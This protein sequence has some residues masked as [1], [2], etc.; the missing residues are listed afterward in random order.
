METITWN[1]RAYRHNTITRSAKFIT[2]NLNGLLPLY[3]DELDRIKKY[4]VK[5][6]IASG[7]LISLRN[8]IKSQIE[9]KKQHVPDYLIVQ[10]RLLFSRLVSRSLTSKNLWPEIKNFFSRYS[11]PVRKIIEIVTET[12]SYNEL[13]DINKAMIKRVL[14]DSVKYDKK[15]QVNAKKFEDTVVKWFRENTQ[16]PFRTE[17]DILDDKSHKLTPDLLFDKPIG[18]IIEGKLNMVNWIDAKNYTLADIP[19]IIKSVKRQ[20]DKYNREFGPGAFIFSHSFDENIHID[21]ALLL[22]GA[23]QR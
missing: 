21:G 5:N 1:N 18:I 2:N 15:I 3:R 10:I 16:T 19:F 4:G 13:S 11:F 12:D 20:A 9:I 22:N 7:T 14:D 8:L 23:A 17:K 6:N